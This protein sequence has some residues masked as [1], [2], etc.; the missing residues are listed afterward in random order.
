[1][2]RNDVEN[3]VASETVPASLVGRRPTFRDALVGTAVV[4]A[5]NASL[6]Q[7]GAWQSVAT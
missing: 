2:L 6:A 5:V 7:D 1:M 4:D 3:L